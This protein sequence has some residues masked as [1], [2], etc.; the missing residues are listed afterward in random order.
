[1]NILEDVAQQF[2]RSAK[3][4]TFI[5]LLSLERAEVIVHSW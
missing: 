3:E 5:Q 2:C 1:M 4:L